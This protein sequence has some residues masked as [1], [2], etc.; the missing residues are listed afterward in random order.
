M[1]ITDTHI[2]TSR[3]KK[4]RVY[5]FS[6]LLIAQL[7][8]FDVQAEQTIS[9]GTTESPPFWSQTLPEQGIC[10]EILSEIAREIN[11]K[12]TLNFEPLKRLI[13]DHTHNHVGDY[14]FWEGKQAFSAI[15]PIFFYRSS[16]FY[17]LPHQHG[18]PIV[19]QN[20]SDLK[21]YTLGVLKGSIADQQYFE[22]EGIRIEESYANE[23]LFKKL[24]LNRIDLCGAIDLTGILIIDQLF[25]SEK[26]LF[27]R[28]EIPESE[29]VIALMIDINYPDGKNL[30]ERFQTGLQTIM[31]SGKYNAILKKYYG[32]ANI[33]EGWL[34]RLKDY[35]KQYQNIH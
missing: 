3:M 34:D 16:F 15:I 4:N 9:F 28:I 30:G 24:H 32:E 23:S 27:R 35:A 22:Q 12:A 13:E 10:G 25:P 2:E 5:L 8:T 1:N 29:T 7:I 33:P 21:G 6:S 18:K 11:V 26:S 31:T 17:Y 19:Y 14:G 20:L